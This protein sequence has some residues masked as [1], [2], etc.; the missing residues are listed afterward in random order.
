MEQIDWN[1]PI[2][3]YSYLTGDFIK[4][5]YLGTYTVNNLVYYVVGAPWVSCDIDETLLVVDKCGNG[6]KNFN[7]VR[8]KKEE[9]TKFV[10]LYVDAYGKY[11]FFVFN[12][13]EVHTDINSVKKYMQEKYP[14]CKIL[15]V[16]EHEVSV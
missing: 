14:T 12:K 15:S 8:N 13:S 2:E 11:N 7:K 5:K 10:V 4:A 6:I 1:K 3:V 9:K 16:V